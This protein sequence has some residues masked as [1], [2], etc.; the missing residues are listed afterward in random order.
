MQATS[1]LRHEVSLTN[2]ARRPHRH[3][4]VELDNLVA[5]RYERGSIIVTSDRSFEQW[6][7]ILGD[8][9]VDAALINRLVHHG[10]MIALKG[11]SDRLRERASTSC[12][13]PRLRRSATPPERRTRA[14]RSPSPL[15]QAVRA[16]SVGSNF[17]RPS[18]RGFNRRCCTFGAGNWRALFDAP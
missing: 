5:R 6:G 11:K 12:P 3:E 15:W 14:D 10:T 13:P 17:V 9:M 16:A 18:Q 1:A 8:A 7:E 2:V 4:L